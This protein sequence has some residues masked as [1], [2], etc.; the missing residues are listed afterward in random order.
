MKECE[1]CRH[2]FPPNPK[3]DYPAMERHG[4]KGSCGRP[5]LIHGGINLPANKKLVC[6]YFERRSP[7]LVALEK[8]EKLQWETQQ[9][10]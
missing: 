10:G 6:G 8:K 1:G 2:F 9:Q 4:F 5:N 7:Q 3:G